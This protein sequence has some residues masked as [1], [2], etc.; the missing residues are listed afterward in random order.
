MPHSRTLRRVC[1]E[2]RHSHKCCR[3]SSLLSFGAVGKELGKRWRDL[4]D[5]EKKRYEQASVADRARAAAAAA[6]YTPPPPEQL[7]AAAAAEAAA[8]KP[9]ARLQR[10]SA[11]LAA[12]LNEQPD[13]M[14]SSSEVMK[15]L[16]AYF[17]THSLQDPANGQ[18]IL[19]DA[20]LLTLFGEQNKKFKGF[21][22]SCLSLSYA[23]I[24]CAD[25]A[26]GA[27]RMAKMLKPHLL[28]SGGAG[29]AASDDDSDEEDEVA[30]EAAE[31]AEA[32]GGAAQGD[33]DMGE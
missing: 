26:H 31:V 25:V 23:I 3:H 20:A 4:P 14:L 8:R 19:A 33:A 27:A 5:A 22:E 11:P 13:A 29:A 16:W 12:F 24:R 9:G 1:Q 17:K 21:G 28:G 18:F 6:A 7:A 15:R 2:H 30:A 10:L 32:A